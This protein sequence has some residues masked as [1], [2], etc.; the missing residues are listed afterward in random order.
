MVFIVILFIATVC[1]GLLINA[2]SVRENDQPF[3]IIF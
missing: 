1:G 3:A 2:P